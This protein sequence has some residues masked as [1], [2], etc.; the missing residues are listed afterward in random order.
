MR[1]FSVGIDDFYEKFPFTTPRIESCMQELIARYDI[2]GKSVLSVGAGGA[3]EEKHFARSGNEVLLIDIDEGGGILPRLEAMPQKPGISYWIGD[4]A[5]FENGLGSYDVLYYSGFTPDELRRASIVRTN[6]NEARSWAIDDDPFHP[7]V[8]G[9][10]SAINDGGL[11]LIQ[12]Y[13]GGIDHDYNANYLA[14]CQRQLAEH[15]L[16][17]LEVHRFTS[18]HGVMLYAAIKGKRQRA[19]AEPISQFHG[20]ATPEPVERVFA[21]S[22]DQ[23]F[24]PITPPKR[25]PIQL[26][27]AANRRLRRLVKGSYGRFLRYPLL[28]AQ[29][30]GSANPHW[31][32][33][34]AFPTSTLVASIAEMTAKLPERRWKTA[35]DHGCGTGDKAPALRSIADQ[36]WGV[37]VLSA[38]GVSN[39]DRYIRVPIGTPAPLAT[40]DDGTVDVVFIFNYAGL[41]STST[42]RAYFSPANDRLAVYLEPQNFPRIIPKGGYLMVSE[43]EAAPEERWGKASLAEIDSRARAAYDPPELPGFELAACGFTAAGRAPYVIYRR[44]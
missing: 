35:I 23:T 3:F 42:W 40:I 5:E 1:K 2:T 16:Y 15:D 33:Y 38:Q 43:W 29:G 30:F 26:W 17:L 31:Q 18:T 27:R 11:L 37:D 32:D 44:V 9:Y 8:M 28:R 21:A 22:G 39:V 41:R 7:V 36:V 12:S 25:T 14:A 10:T 6:A 20:R 4:A 19:P 24:L 13:C 34:T